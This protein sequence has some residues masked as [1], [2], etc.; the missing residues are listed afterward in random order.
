LL[1]RESWDHFD[2]RDLAVTMQV[3]SRVVRAELGRVAARLTAR[4]RRRKIFASHRRI[5]QKLAGGGRPPR[6]LFL[7]YGNI[8]RSPVAAAM[9][10]ASLAGVEIRSAGFHRVAER[11]TPEHVRRAASRAG[12]DMT[13]HASRRVSAEDIRTADLIVCMDAENLEHLQREFPEAMARATL[14]GLFAAPPCLEIEDPYSLSEERTDGVMSAIRAGIDGLARRL[15][16]YL[17]VTPTS[18]SGSQVASSGNTVISAMQ[19]TI[20]KKKGSEASAT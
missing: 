3:L 1:G 5:T 19:S 20:M 6:I 10:G 13:R 11:S 16:D 7:C 9:A 8:C 12:C 15:Q 18:V 17:R 2:R 4:R 14:L